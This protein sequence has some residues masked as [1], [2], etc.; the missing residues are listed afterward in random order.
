MERAIQEQ[1]DM[2]FRA[3]EK[4]RKQNIFGSGQMSFAVN[5]VLWIPYITAYDWL[6]FF[7]EKLSGEYLLGRTSGLLGLITGRP[8][9]PMEREVF[10]YQFGGAALTTAAA[11]ACF[12]VDAFVNFGWIGVI[13]YAG[14]FAALTWVVVKQG[15]P[16]MQACYYYFALQ[17]SMGGLSGV[18]FSNGMIF[19][20]CLAFFVRLKLNP[21]SH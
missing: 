8:I 2:D 7:H 17:A 11:N 3:L 4:F 10:S 5:R 15:N 9:F 6:S 1:L 14:L 12:L 18:L 16:A 19:L 21:V 13:V 20:I